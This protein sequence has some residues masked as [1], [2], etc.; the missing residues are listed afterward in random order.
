MLLHFEITELTSAAAL[1]NL[2]GDQE[3]TDHRKGH[4]KNGMAEFDERKV[5]LHGEGLKS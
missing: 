2:L 3:K 5:G 4:G 1:A